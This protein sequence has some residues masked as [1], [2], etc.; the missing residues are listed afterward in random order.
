MLTC[1]SNVFFKCEE[2]LYGHR[3]AHSHPGQRPGAHPGVTAMPCPSQWPQPLEGTPPGGMTPRAAPRAAPRAGPPSHAAGHAG[4]RLPGALCPVIP[5]TALCWGSEAALDARTP[6]SPG[7]P[8]QAGSL[9]PALCVT[10]PQRPGHHAQHRDRGFGPLPGPRLRLPQCHPGLPVPCPW[11][12]TVH[13]QGDS[14]RAGGGRG[15]AGPRPQKAVSAVRTPAWGAL[16][17]R[18]PAGAACPSRLLPQRELG[19]GPWHGPR[20]CP[21]SP[22][23]AVPSPGHRRPGHRGPSG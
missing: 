10:G 13:M 1:A 6:T 16:G 22:A 5:V 9:S 2:G 12:P 15:E 4:S 21:V 19:P 17:T 18:G 11:A 7:P 3:L 20:P 8:P 23:C 14:P